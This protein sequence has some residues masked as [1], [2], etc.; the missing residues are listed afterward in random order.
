[1]CV[2][3]RLSARS[4]RI[5]SLDHYTATVSSPSGGREARLETKGSAWAK[6]QKVSG[7]FGDNSNTFMRT[8]QAAA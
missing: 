2:Y 4:G 6:L 3:S 1:M 5:E 8:S 7:V